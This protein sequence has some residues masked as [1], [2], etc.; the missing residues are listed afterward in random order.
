MATSQSLVTVSAVA[1][2]I[3]LASEAYISSPR[4]QRWPWLLAAC[5]YATTGIGTPAAH[6]VHEPAPIINLM[7][8]LKASLATAQGEKPPKKIAPSEG[9]ERR[10][11][12]KKSS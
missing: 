5:F 10:G 6:P 2:L 3:R 9:E 1:L 7:D 8:A 12:K 4:S 11:R